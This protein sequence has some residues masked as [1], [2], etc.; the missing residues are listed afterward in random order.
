MVSFKAEF[1]S[2]EADIQ[3]KMDELRDTKTKLE[4]NEKIKKDM[5]V[6][7]LPW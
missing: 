3:K 6:S 7:W 2:K 1:E 5:M 4:Q